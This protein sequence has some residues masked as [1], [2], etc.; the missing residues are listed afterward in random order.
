MRRDRGVV[1]GE[2]KSDP[3]RFTRTPSFDSLLMSP[4]SSVSDIVANVR[5][6]R[7]SPVELVQDTLNRIE[8]LNPMLGAFITVSAES[9]LEAAHRLEE[10]VKDKDSLGPL[11]GVPV[12]IKDIVATKDAPTT[13]G[14]RIF[15]SGFSSEADAPVVK[16]LRRA[17]AIVI[18]KNNLHEVALGVTGVNEHFGPARNPWDPD[19]V[20]GGSSGGSAVAVAAGLGTLSLGSDTRGSI[21]IPAACCG[22]TGFKP[23]YGLLP[24]DDVIPLSP[25]LDHLGPMARSVEDAAAMLA[26]MVKGE[27]VA[28]RIR[29][30]PGAKTKRLVLGISEY[31]LRDMDRN[32][33]RVV[34][35]AIDALR[36]LVREVREVKIPELEGVQEASGFITSG[37]AVTYHD[38]WLKETPDAYG[39][40]VRERLAAGYQRTALEYL[41]AQEKRAQVTAAFA[42][43]F[44]TVDLLVGATLPTLPCRI[45]EQNVLIDGKEVF[46]V[47]AFTVFNSPQN[48]AGLPALSVPCGFADGMPVGLQLFGAHGRD[49][50]VL[51]LGGAWQRATDWHQRVPERFS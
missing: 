40:L 21:R 17:G 44:E 31:H 45:G 50:R 33:A 27:K 39:P 7:I 8:R 30:A 24:V 10:S 19:R 9:A 51:A 2:R 16:R 13:A 25:S 29:R 26:A 46:V 48:M 3:P 18:G 1:K 14:S 32:V 6:R 43:E 47:T 5:H 23:S 12:S 37:D 11:A 20:S 15:G 28:A 38:R 4:F 42:R 22:I 35:A 49:T 41:K 36:P 34:E